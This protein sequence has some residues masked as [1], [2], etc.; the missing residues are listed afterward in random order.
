MTPVFQAILDKI[1]SLNDLSFLSFLITLHGKC[2][3]NLN[4][5]M[6]IYS[7]TSIF[8]NNSGIT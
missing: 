8:R 3:Y 7:K 5:N 2:A 6:F 1:G 4:R